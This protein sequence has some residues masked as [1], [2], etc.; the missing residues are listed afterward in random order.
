[1]LIFF[2]CDEYIN[3]GGFLDKEEKEVFLYFFFFLLYLEFLKLIFL[4]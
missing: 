3:V 2:C 4:C 1:M